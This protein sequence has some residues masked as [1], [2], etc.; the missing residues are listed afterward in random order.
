[1][2]IFKFSTV[3]GKKKKTSLKPEKD[4]TSGAGETSLSDTP[5]PL[6]VNADKTKKTRKGT[7]K[8]MDGEG[9]MDQTSNEEALPL[10]SLE[11]SLQLYAQVDMTKKTKKHSVTIWRD[12]CQARLLKSIKARQL[13]MK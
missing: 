6:Y 13:P 7:G 3:S 12:L 2:E 8:R 5:F 1:M 10:K 4:D 9:K 11:P